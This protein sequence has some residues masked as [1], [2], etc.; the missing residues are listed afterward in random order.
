MRSADH[1]GM[2]SH[3]C[4]QGDA[5]AGGAHRGPV[6]GHLGVFGRRRGQHDGQLGHLRL[7]SSRAIY[8]SKRDSHSLYFLIRKLM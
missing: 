4:R 8:V 5:E 3:L 6:E 7:Q 1:D 2:R